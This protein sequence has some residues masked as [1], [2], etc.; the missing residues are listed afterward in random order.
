MPRLSCPG[1]AAVVDLPNLN[2][3]SEE[4]CP[5]CDFPLF[6]AGAGARPDEEGSLAL[7]VRRRPGSSGHQLVATETCPECQ[8]L[9]KPSNVY[10]HRCGAEMHPQ[11][12]LVTAVAR[13]VQAPPPAPDAPTT[14]LAQA[15]VEVR[16]WWR[17]WLL[18]AL[19]FFLLAAVAIASVVVLALDG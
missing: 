14:P 8:E 15:P 17:G 4:F 19:L 1:C 16:P 3:S 5:S 2:R 9:N 10:C 6:W 11:A 18:V 7:A 12:P 13:T